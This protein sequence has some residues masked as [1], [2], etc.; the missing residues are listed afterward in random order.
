MSFV[1]I[2]LGASLCGV[3]I[4]RVFFLI[5]SLFCHPSNILKKHKESMRGER[6]FH[7]AVGDDRSDRC[8]STARDGVRMT[9]AVK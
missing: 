8:G 4:A 9:H 1:I 3:S 5:F 7:S 6:G 2:I